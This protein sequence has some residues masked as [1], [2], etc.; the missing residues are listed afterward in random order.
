[1]HVRAVWQQQT[2]EQRVKQRERYRGMA[3]SIGTCVETTLGTGVL[4]EIRQDD[5]V[6][7]VRL[8]RSRGAGSAKAYLHPGAVLRK[9]P[10]AV[11]VRVKTP[12]GDGVVV[13]FM[14]G[15]RGGG[16]GGGGGVNKADVF[17]VQ[18]GFSADGE[19]ALVEGDS[20]SCPV[21]K[22]MPLVERVLDRSN[23]LV[24]AE[25]KSA[26]GTGARDILASI[27]GT[28]YG[29]DAK[30]ALGAAAD[31]LDGGEKA[32]RA[33]APATAVTGEHHEEGVGARAETGGHTE[34]DGDGSGRGE[35]A[36]DAEAQL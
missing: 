4:V 22:V 18:M 6:H 17:L 24:T 9:L 14:S 1:Q 16:G 23:A 19:M 12:E 10:A 25:T 13:G 31:T 3:F 26:I 30:A 7:V 20:I 32:S 36:R 34:G 8:W 15:G 35:S 21:A 2:E 33:T 11:G 27:E 28:V 29:V 5:G